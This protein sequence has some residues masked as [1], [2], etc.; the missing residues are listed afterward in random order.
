MAR[1]AASQK[2]TCPLNIQGGTRVADHA[3]V[4]DQT[5]IANRSSVAH[6]TRF[7]VRH[8]HAIGGNRSAALTIV[9]A[10]TLAV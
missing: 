1:R 4:A 6:R 5:G 10:T 8:A 3:R 9:N 2:C 7:A